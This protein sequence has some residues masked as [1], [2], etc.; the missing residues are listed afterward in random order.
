MPSSQ[1]LS[2][3]SFVLRFCN[4]R[5]RLCEFVL[6]VKLSVC[7]SFDLCACNVA[8][9]VSFDVLVTVFGQVIMPGQKNKGQRSNLT[10]F[11]CNIQVSSVL[12]TQLFSNIKCIDD[13]YNWQ[14]VNFL[15]IILR[16]IHC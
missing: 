8:F 11:D 1:T 2:Q 16:E 6:S 3:V 15:V 12:C 7:N 14:V 10:P 5:F 13:Y 4:Q 9:L